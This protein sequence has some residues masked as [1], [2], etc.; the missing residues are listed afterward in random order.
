VSDFLSMGGYAAFVWPSYGVA[1]A[2]MG[3][4]LLWAWRSAVRGEAEVARLRSAG[5]D[6][7][8]SSGDGA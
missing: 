3:G 6:P 7:R 5:L 1:F 4:L 2:V 8:R